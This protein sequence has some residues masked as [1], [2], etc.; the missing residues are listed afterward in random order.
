MDRDIKIENLLNYMNKHYKYISNT[1]ERKIK[2][3]KEHCEVVTVEIDDLE[4]CLKNK[5][6]EIELLK[7]YILEEM[8]SK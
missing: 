2:V 1:V 6:L 3:Y 4:N 7:K 5:D 8:G